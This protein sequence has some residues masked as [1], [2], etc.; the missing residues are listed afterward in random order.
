LKIPSFKKYMSK[1][2]PSTNK[3]F[4]YF[5]AGSMGL[6]SAVGAKATVHGMFYNRNWMQ[7]WA[8]WC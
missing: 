6:G 4:S 5:V 8:L 3:V 2:S 7:N 1:S